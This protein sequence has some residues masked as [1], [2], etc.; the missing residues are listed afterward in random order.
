[1]TRNDA[2]LDVPGRRPARGAWRSYVALGDSFTEGVGDPDPVTG[3]ERGWADRVAAALAR[4]RPD[5]GYANLAIRGLLLDRVVATQVPEAV[6]LAP[7]LVSICAAGNDLLRPSADPDALAERLEGA[8]A[9]LRATGADVLVF[10]GF[11]T[12]ESPLLNLIAR[13]LAAMNQHIRDI[14]ARQDAYLVDL[15]AMAPLADA[16]ARTD[17]RL[18]L[19]AAGHAKVAARVC[20]VL[21]LAARGAHHVD[22]A[23][24]RGRPLGPRAPVAV[25]AAARA[26]PQHGRPPPAEAPAA[27]SPAMRILHDDLTGPEI[28]A[29]LDEHLEEMRAVSPPESTHALDLEGLRAQDVTFWTVWDEGALLGCGALREL[30]PSHGEIKSMRTASA[31]QGRGVGAALVVH[32]VAEARR[33]GYR[34]LSLETGSSA[35]FAPARRLYARHGFVPCPPFGDYPDDPHSAHMELAL[36]DARP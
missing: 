30:D 14:A 25:A 29:L 11:N 6:R 15:W 17:D 5:V 1:V 31:H 32:V 7:D 35:H 28:A 4:G 26:G 27:R 16:R 19:N 21:G 20:E 22:R 9:T 12:R 33:R 34:R 36:D 10:T 2:S 18:H 23:P 13:R 24:H 3:V 8:V